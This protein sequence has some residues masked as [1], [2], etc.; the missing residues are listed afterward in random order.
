MVAGIE[1]ARVVGPTSRF[2]DPVVPAGATQHTAR[3]GVYV[4]AGD[5]NPERIL[6][7]DLLSAP[8]TATTEVLRRYDGR[9]GRLRLRELQA[10][11][12][13]HADRRAGRPPARDHRRRRRRRSSRWRRTTWRT[14]TRSTRRR[15]STRSQR[16][17]SEPGPDDGGSRGG[18]GQ[19]GRGDVRLVRG[20][21]ERLDRLV[22]AI[23][24]AGV[25]ITTGA[26]STVYNREGGEPGGNIRV[27]FLF[28][29]DRGVQ[30]VDRGGRPR[31]RRRACTPTPT[32]TRT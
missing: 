5:F 10:P 9:G 18:P 16:R 19:R 12:L 3:G 23:A 22:A 29:T 25:S 14:S 31:R 27:A 1:Q 28:R 11:A 21:P 32:A 13:D 24:A 2:G 7:D 30:F 20:G 6:V 26:R 4:S 8:A 17:S 15:S